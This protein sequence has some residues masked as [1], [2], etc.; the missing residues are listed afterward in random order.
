MLGSLRS[1][2]VLGP[3]IPVVKPNGDI[4]VCVDFRRVNQVTR[5]VHF[6][7]PTLHDILEK[8]GHSSMI[9]TLD[10]T[11][12]FHQVEVE[13]GSKDITMLTCPWGRYRYNRMPFGL[14]NAPAVFQCLME[15]VLKPCCEYAV[16]YIDDIIVFSKSW[17]EHVQHLREVLKVLR[18]AGLTAHPSKCAWGKRTVKYLGHVVGS[19]K[20]AVPEHRIE[21]MASYK[22]PV[23]KNN[24]R[25]FLGS[26]G[27]YRDF[28]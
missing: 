1:L 23:T 27:C 25:T 22:H 14:K 8:V 12:G 17:S 3:M 13:E 26:V 24:L 10:M 18:K 2:I 20:V 15:K 9:S 11:K 7:I 16:V 4:K 5:Q 28:I 6:Y 21:A 19:V